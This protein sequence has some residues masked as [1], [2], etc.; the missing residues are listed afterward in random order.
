MATDRSYTD[1]VH[2]AVAAQD[3]DELAVALLKAALVHP[4]GHRGDL[5]AVKALD[6]VR[7]LPADVRARL[8]DALAG[9]FR[10]AAEDSPVRQNALV[11]ISA[12]GRDLPGNVLAAERR[13]L[14]LRT[15]RL[16]HTYLT[17]AEQELVGAELAAGRTLPPPVVATVRRSALGSYAGPAL[18]E[19]A[20]RLTGPVL[21]VGEAWAE[22]AMADGDHWHALLAHAVT[23]TAAKPSAKWE[24]TARARCGAAGDADTVRGRLLGWLGLVG[25]PRTLVLDEER[26]GPDANALWDPYNANALR[27]LAWLLAVLP[28]HPDSVRALGRLAGA[29]LRGLPGHG[30]LAP[31]VATACVTALSRMDG[32]EGLA[33]LAR[34]ATRVTFKGTRKVLDAALEARAAALGLGREEVEE[35]AVPA[36]GLTGIGQGAHPVGGYTALLE[37]RGARVQLTWRAPGG[38]TVKSVPAVVRRDHPEE[39]K[40]LRAAA[41]DIDRMLGAQVERLDRQFLA[42]RSWRYAQWRERL[43]D[44]PLVG[45]V[46]RGLLWVVDGTAVGFAGGEA[47]TLDGTPVTGGG[48]VVLWHPVDRA[49]E[50]AAA[51]AERLERH[52]VVQPFKQAHREVYALT[53]VERTVGAYCDRFAGR[54][55]HQHRFHSLAAARGWRNTLRLAVDDVAPPAVRELPAWGMRAEFRI[56]PD[57]SETGPD[58]ITDSGAFRRLTTGQLRFYPLDAPQ[59]A[60]HCCGG[61]YT[62][63]PRDGRPPADP[64][65]LT[66]VPAL[67]LSEILRDVDLFVNA[68]DGGRERPTGR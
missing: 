21:N 59:H 20:P 8:A 2:R 11:L 27:G 42:R 53:G 35:L 10:A 65:P 36:Y 41:K 30:P 1:A 56:D 43:A 18:A 33:E 31:K 51:W 58:D 3:P 7:A 45:T 39:V 44:H 5:L 24:R 57:P 62:V 63:H 46:A 29:A 37:V 22:R 38:R 16:R 40:E 61:A 55:L 12:V 25:A 48:E 32:E 4:F 49:P 13:E 54:V 26:Y 6:A 64:L 66:A 28:P 47:R 50:E 14:L 60:A 34:L 15:G 52:G 17:G 68:A 19:I 67:V 23:A 9:R